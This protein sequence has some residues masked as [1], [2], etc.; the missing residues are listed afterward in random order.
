M[1]FPSGMRMGVDMQASI[2]MKFLPRRYLSVNETQAP[3][4]PREVHFRAESED[5]QQ[6]G[7]TIPPNVLATADRVIR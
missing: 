3:R 1:I 6:I 4:S 7:L 5:R 2:R